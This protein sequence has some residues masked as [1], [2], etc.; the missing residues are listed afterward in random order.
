MERNTHK[1][2]Q[3][4]AGTWTN[5][6]LSEDDTAQQLVLQAFHVDGEVNDGRLGAHFRSVRR[7]WQFGGNVKPELVGHIHVLVSHFHLHGKKN[8]Q[9]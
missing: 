6:L 8:P 9:E 4:D 7:I 3:I 1:A 5:L 2:T